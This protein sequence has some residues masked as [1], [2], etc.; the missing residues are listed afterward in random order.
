MVLGSPLSSAASA[1]A[2]AAAPAAGFASAAF[3]SAVSGSITAL[4]GIKPNSFGVGRASVGGSS[5]NSFEGKGSTENSNN[6]SGMVTATVIEVD[7][8]RFRA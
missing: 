3:A 7:P 6:F 5:S 4:P 2:G 1:F 8:S